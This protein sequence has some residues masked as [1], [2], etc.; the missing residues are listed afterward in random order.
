[1]KIYGK[2]AK[3]PRRLRIFFPLFIDMSGRK[4]LVIGGGNI[5]ERR[6]KILSGFGADITVISPAATGYIEDAACRGAICLHKRKYKEGDIAGIMPM[7][8]IA[9]S[10]ERRVNQN[11]MMEA[12]PL[13]IQV[14]V[15]D[16]L[17]ECT[18]FFPAIAES[19]DYIAA[20]VSKNGSHRG[21][22][23]MAK[24]MREMLSL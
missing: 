10:D 15:A 3:K 24:K 20:L 4:V 8:V 5:A 18:C 12:S 11:A 9:A 14:S 1:M 6:I 23:A 22:K 13:N 7:L 16:C 17:E 21:V 2:D 19:G